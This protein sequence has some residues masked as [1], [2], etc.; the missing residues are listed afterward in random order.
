ME[1]L[2]K[3]GQIVPKHSKDI[4]D[5]KM[6]IGFEKL[7]RD[8]F[9][10]EKA[11]DRVAEL[12]VKWVRLQSGWQ[13]TERKKGVY[14]F[15][16]LDKIVDNLISRGLRPWFCLCYGN[17]LYN[18]E[19]K[20]IFGAV[21]CVP[22]HTEE[23][24][25][26]WKNYVTALARHF[27]G[28]VGYYE[29]WNE[30][31]CPNS[32]R[33]N[34][35]TGAT[36]L[37]IFTKETGLAVKAAD[38]DA[39]VI[40][41]VLGHRDIDYPNAALAAGMG[42][43]ID[44]LTFHEYTHDETKVFER[45]DALRALV[46]SYSPKIGI[47]QGESGSQSRSGGHGAVFTGAWT[48]DKQAKQLLRHAMADLLSDVYFTSYFSCMDMIDALNGRVG[49]VASYLDYGYFGVLGA[50]FDAD[51]KCVGSYTPKKSYYALQNLCSV[52]AEGCELCKLPALFV[53]QESPRTFG[54]DEPKNRVITGG[55]RREGGD[56]LVYWYPS[57]IMTSSFESTISLDICSKYDKVR[58]VDLMDGAIY[59]IPDSIL[60]KDAFG[61]YHLKNLPVK[62]TPMLLTF[63]EFLN[64]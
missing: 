56:A 36:D 4:Q 57:N 28:R 34:P 25:T 32:W 52:F 12:G 33:S 24:K 5:S 35:E 44:Y 47:I 11:Y 30:P 48:Q 8:V 37:G 62:D 9:D 22:I 18:E 49:D 53:P 51:G 2:H 60:T 3:V 29:V 38:P 27:R 16:W 10:P 46:K 63:G 59:E 50:D 42:E 17:D 45:V 61:T 40:G 23:Q 1:R 41:G 15:A 54:M 58:L 55:F 43:V 19:A 13:K 14:D 31:D 6:G 21:G 64:N 26:A 39:K 20:E 7:D